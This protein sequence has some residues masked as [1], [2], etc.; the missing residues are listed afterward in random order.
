MF[1]NT[2]CVTVALRDGSSQ[3]WYLIADGLQLQEHRHTGLDAVRHLGARVEDAHCEGVEHHQH[4]AL[5]L[6]ARANHAVDQTCPSQGQ[7]KGATGFVNIRATM[8]DI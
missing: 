8:N 6:P 1:R 7:T 3:C 2:C 5:V 4:V